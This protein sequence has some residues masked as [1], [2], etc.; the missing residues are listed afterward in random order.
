MIENSGLLLDFYRYF[1]Y[2]QFQVLE[3]NM[4]HLSY[5]WLKTSSIIAFWVS[6][7]Q[8]TKIYIINVRIIVNL[9]AK[10]HCFNSFTYKKLPIECLSIFC[11]E[12]GALVRGKKKTSASLL[13]SSVCFGRSRGLDACFCPEE[14]ILDMFH[15]F[16]EPCTLP[17]IRK[18]Q[19][20]H[21]SGDFIFCKLLLFQ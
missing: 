2:F 14:E 10:R 5:F 20:N 9:K 16:C 21:P 4:Q 1:R 7:P 17:Q 11:K 13:F 19:A 3:I 8:A 18:L 6:L 15:D 12:I